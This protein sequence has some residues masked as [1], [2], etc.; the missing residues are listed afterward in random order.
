MQDFW[1]WEKQH[2]VL[3][4]NLGHIS[5]LGGHGPSPNTVTYLMPSLRLV[6]VT[7]PANCSRKMGNMVRP[8]KPRSWAYW[9][10]FFAAN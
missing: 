1:L 7:P 3:D 6:K 9:L 10:P 8:E 2:R 4:A 5:P